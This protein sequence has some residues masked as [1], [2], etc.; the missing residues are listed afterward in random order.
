MH[1]PW[2][3][4]PNFTAPMLIAGIAT[5]HV[6][7]SLYAVGGGIVLAGE[8]SHA[9]KSNDR[10]MLDY[11]RTH[12][13]FFILLTVVFGAI[14]GVG[15]WWTIGLASPL[16]TE[17]LIHIF[18][19]GW[20]MEYVFFVI[21]IVSAFVFHYYWGRLDPKTHAAIGWIYAISAYISL[22]LITGI[23][24]FQ[25]DIG[26]WTP[27]KG[28]W[29]AF[30]N[31]QTI[32]Q[33]MARSGAALLLASLYI[34]LH[35]AFKLRND[36]H[37]RSLVENRVSKWGMAGAALVTAGGAWW[38]VNIPESA[39]SALAGASALN[40]LT[41]LIFLASAVVFFMLYFGPYRHPGWL[42][43]GFAILYFLLGI[44]ATGTGE[45][46]REGARK[47]Y[48]VY[49]Y[50]TGNNVLVSE[51]PKL[52]ASGYLNG[53]VWTRAYLKEQY[54]QAVTKDGNIDYAEMLKLP[55]A[56][57]VK[58]GK[59]LFQY[60]CNDC[61]STNGFSG[62]DRLTQGWTRDMISTVVTHLNK[63]H[64]F[65]PPWC[66]N[67]AEAVLITEFIQSL[68]E[69]TP[70]GMKFSEEESSEKEKTSNLAAREESDR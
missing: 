18:V 68:S 33:I 53:G 44:A 51:I 30:F 65:M 47:P 58:V 1:Y 60:H 43:P 34:Y 7:V 69:P 42:N 8:V 62:L 59:V 15:I 21:E 19:F 4:V 12:T 10:P 20:A 11:L 45:F 36:V 50:V 14:T 16:A 40:I 25:L 35:A 9:Y 29:T 32:P 61:H 55:V 28:M 27:E 6:F 46:I 3:Y 57:Q 56:E 52:Q 66:G 41:A 54:P 2:W 13:L 70:A 31:P 38:Y 37:L 63:A 23:T 64:Y 5:I 17:S 39:K 67:D 26:N 22:V 48:I 24:A 49:N